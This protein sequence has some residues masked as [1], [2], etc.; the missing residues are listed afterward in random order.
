VDTC[1][2]EKSVALMKEA[3]D[4][5]IICS[6]RIADRVRVEFLGTKEIYHATAAFSA[7]FSDDHHQCWEA[8]CDDSV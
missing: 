7:L 1:L 5:A 2:V 8:V 3:E 4:A 6:N